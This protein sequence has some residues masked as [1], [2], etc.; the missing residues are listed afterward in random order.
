MS[1]I[2][3]TEMEI[4]DKCETNELT[5]ANSE[6]TYTDLQVWNGYVWV[7]VSAIMSIVGQCN[8]LIG[9]YLL[10]T[11]YATIFPTPC[12]KPTNLGKNTPHPR[13][14]TQA[15]RKS[16]KDTWEHDQ[17]EFI[18]CENYQHMIKEKITVAVLPALF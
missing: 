13:G 9:Y 7:N 18:T 10:S 11:L 8:C 15:A 3:L 16:I 5:R 14:A 2:V 4:L 12:Q 17:F 6:P 1:K